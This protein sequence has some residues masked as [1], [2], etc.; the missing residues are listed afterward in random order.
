[1]K[2]TTRFAR[3]AGACCLVGF[4]LAGTSITSGQAPD[5]L[6]R[7][8]AL[9]ADASYDEALAVLKGS[10][11]AEAHQYRALC[12]IAL[13][14]TQEAERALEALINAAPTY[15]VNDA[16]LPPR[17]VA[18]YTQTRRRIIPAVVKRMFTEAR[19]DFQAKNMAAARDKFEKV[20]VLTRDP[21]MAGSAEA[22]DLELLV[23]SYIDI[24]KNSAPSLVQASGPVVV[25]TF[26]APA[27]IAP[28]SVPSVTSAGNQ[29]PAGPRTTALPASATA[30][31]AT[32]PATVVTSSTAGATTAAATTATTRVTPAAG[33]VPPPPPANAVSMAAVVPAVTAARRVVPA[34][35]IRQDFPAFTASGPSRPMSGAVRVTI[36]S[37]GKVKNA[38]MEV[39]IDARYDAKVLAAAR[40]WRYKPATV[41]GEP[42]QSE[43]VVHINVAK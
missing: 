26:A 25:G 43:K 2:T 7:A 23:A 19:A 32:T 18:M 6:A 21:A 8:R 35:T 17:I 37:D 14:R 40:N 28:P 11:A 27:P 9:Y 5:T 15:A 38:V 36:G 39:P 1:M 13:G 10:D 33:A 34:E 4:V 30:S 29:A 22:V 16:D 31:M 20:L 24:V 41:G 42:I 3:H 12:L